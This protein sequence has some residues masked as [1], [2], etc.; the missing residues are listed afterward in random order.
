MSFILQYISEIEGQPFLTTN[1]KTSHPNSITIGY[2][3]MLKYQSQVSDI[4]INSKLKIK[5]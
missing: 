2:L 5:N 3:Q 1:I 4:V